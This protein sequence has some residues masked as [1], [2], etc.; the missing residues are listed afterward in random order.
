MSS[1]PA[2]RAEIVVDLAAIR[3]NVRR[4]RDLVSAATTPATMTV[5]KADAYGHGM[6]EV[7][8]AARAAGSDWLGVATLDEALALRASGDVGPLFAWLAVPG[9]EYQPVL[10]AGVEV[11]GYT[12]SQLDGIIAAG[13]EIGVQPRVHLKIDTGLSRGG[14]HL[15]DWAALCTHAA[16]LE[17]TGA[18]AITGVWSHFAASDEPEH[19]ANDAQLG[20]F[21]EALE[22]AEA[23]GLTPQWRHICNSAGALL[24]PDA[25]FDMVR[26]G[27]ASYGIDPAPGRRTDLGLIPAMTVRAKL[28]MVKEIDAGAGVSYGHTWI[29]PRATRVGLVPAGYGE[30]IP[31]AAGNRAEVWAAGARRPIR[32]VVCMDQFVIELGDG[33]ADPG[34][35][36]ELFG[37]GADGRVTAQDW[38][39]ACGTISYEIVTRI[40]GRFT[41]VHVDSEDAQ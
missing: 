28:A 21:K 3:H 13:A 9:E 32:G 23:A 39:D 20:V 8:R 12:V 34:D 16:A 15:R 4:L 18:V 26:F 37:T 17:R 27:L 19:P 31:R 25:H 38:A 14:A 11:A 36:V 40:G 30:G 24:R 41:R 22:I 29:A 6:V 10:A 35:E 5:V 2:R 33:E 7:A 1:T